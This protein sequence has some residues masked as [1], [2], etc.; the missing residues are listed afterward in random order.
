MKKKS[1]NAGM[2]HGNQMSTDL[3]DTPGFPSLEEQM[4]YW[5]RKERQQQV[6]ENI[7]ELIDKMRSTIQHLLNAVSGLK[8]IC[9][10]QQE[11]IDKLENTFRDINTGV[12]NALNK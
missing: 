12:R 11:R 2:T 6:N 1:E 10:H 4:A 3:K 5:E 9:E 7:V 8:D